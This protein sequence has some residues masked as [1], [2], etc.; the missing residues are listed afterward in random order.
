MLRRNLEHTYQ[1][2]KRYKM[3]NLSFHLLK[4]TKLNLKYAEVSNKHS[5][6]IILKEIKNRKPIEKSDKIKIQ[7]LKWSTKLANL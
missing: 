3:N 1:Y 5:E 6:E 7:F 4:K 2:L